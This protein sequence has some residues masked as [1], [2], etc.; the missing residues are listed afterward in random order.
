MIILNGKKFAANNDQF[1]GSL[2]SGG[3]TCVGYYKVRKTGVDLLDM[4]KNKIGVITK[5]QVLASAKRLENGNWWYSYSDIDLIGRYTS[6]CQERNE[7]NSVLQ[8]FNII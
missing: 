1:I 2:F 5:H 8:Q 6:Y 7:V 4:Q 3:G